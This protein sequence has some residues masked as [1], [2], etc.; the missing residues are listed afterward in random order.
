MSS[1]PKT[2]P[3]DRRAPSSTKQRDSSTS[4]ATEPQAGR[5]KPRVPLPPAQEQRRRAPWMISV[6]TLAKHTMWVVFA[7]A[8][9]WLWFLVRDLGPVAQLVALA[10]P[11]I[12]VAALIGLDHLGVRRSQALV[13]PR[14]RVGPRVR[15]GDD[16][17]TS[18]GHACLPAPR[19]HP[20]RIDHP[21]RVDPQRER[22]RR[23]AR[24]AAGRHR[25]RRRAVEEGARRAAPSRSLPVHV[26][27]RP[28]RRAID[29]P[30]REAPAAEGSPG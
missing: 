23:F 15:M 11:V 10:L 26:D 19:P 8:I 2:Q 12:V 18:L 29:E 16:R 27:E 22:D 6:G 7:A 14:G 9:P 20:D 25:R 5:R 17:R 13:A 4:P 30:R 28:I 24:E 21:G 1:P 3:E